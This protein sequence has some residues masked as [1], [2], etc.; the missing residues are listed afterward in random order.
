MDLERSDPRQMVEV[1]IDV[2]DLGAGF[3]ALGCEDAVDRA[4]DGEP[5][6]ASRSE[7][8]RRPQVGLDVRL[9]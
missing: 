3:H 2:Q 5:T 4:P 8:I 7:E 9:G 1:A 6:S